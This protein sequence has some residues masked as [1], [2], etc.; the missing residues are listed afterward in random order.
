MPGLVNVNYACGN[1]TKVTILSS[2]SLIKSGVRLSTA[3]GF[4]IY[5][6]YIQPDTSPASFFLSY[7]E[8]LPNDID[9]TPI[10]IAGSDYIDSSLIG[11]RSFLFASRPFDIAGLTTVAVQLQKFKI[12]TPTTIKN[13]TV[14]RLNSDGTAVVSG[15]SKQSIKPMI[16]VLY[17][18]NLPD[19]SFC[20]DITF[21]AAQAPNIDYSL[22][23]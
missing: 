7:K 9:M 12:Q 23:T 3:P 21:T 13:E 5:P 2:S 10:Y 20:S 11:R 18:D 6:T 8:A 15:T 4:D 17:D 1:S 14:R 16:Y 19:Q 22:I